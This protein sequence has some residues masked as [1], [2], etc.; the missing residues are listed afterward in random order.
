M[1]NDCLIIIQGFFF[2]FEDRKQLE[3][4]FIYQR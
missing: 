1:Y 2:K 3:Y 4:L